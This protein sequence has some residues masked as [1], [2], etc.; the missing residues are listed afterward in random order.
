MLRST[1]V[2]Q[3]RVSGLGPGIVSSATPINGV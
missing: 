3:G 2:L 1:P